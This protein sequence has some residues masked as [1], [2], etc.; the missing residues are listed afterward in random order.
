MAEESTRMRAGHLGSC[1]V[2]EVSLAAPRLEPAGAAGMT[3]DVLRIDGHP[4]ES[5]S[6]AG[7][8]SIPEFGNRGQTRKKRNR[9]LTANSIHCDSQYVASHNVIFLSS[10]RSPESAA[11]SQLLNLGLPSRRSW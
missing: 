4:A 9:G 3:G 11:C 1:S 6:P 7:E 5:Y 10:A 8:D 2:T